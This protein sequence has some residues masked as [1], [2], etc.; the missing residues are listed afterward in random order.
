[1]RESLSSEEND[2]GMRVMESRD[3]GNLCI[4]T[5]LFGPKNIHIGWPERRA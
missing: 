4:T 5:P 3:E 1:M 2:N